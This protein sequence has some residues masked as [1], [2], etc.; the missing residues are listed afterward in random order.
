MLSQ[1]ASTLLF[2]IWQQC[3]ITKPL[4]S[5]RSASISVSSVLHHSGACLGLHDVWRAGQQLCGVPSRQHQLLH[6]SPRL[7]QRSAPLLCIC[8]QVERS[9]TSIIGLDQL[10]RVYAGLS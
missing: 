6:S 2:L 7:L 4:P 1:G 9:Q 5:H 3:N 8:L 10:S